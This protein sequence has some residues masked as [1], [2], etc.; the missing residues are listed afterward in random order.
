ME[1]Q[2]GRCVVINLPEEIQKLLGPVQ[3]GNPAHYFTGYDV[4]RDVQARRA[5]ALVIMGSPL[6][7]P[8]PK[9]QHWLSTIQRL[10]LSLLV[11]RQ[12]HGVVRRTQE[13]PNHIN[14]F[15][16]EVRIV[17]DLE[18]LQSVQLEI[19]HS[20]YLSDLLGGNASVLGHQP[21]APVRSFLGN[22]LCCQGQDFFDFLSAQLQ[23]LTATREVVQ[24]VD[25][26]L[27]ITLSP[28]EHGRC[29]DQ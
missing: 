29:R 16:G 3:L 5:M 7:L 15:L 4:E 9:L 25:A 19:G 14:D 18:C 28:L 21:D 12:H 11:N 17:A 27:Q 23:M 2:L 13:E 26:R 20:L 8:R 1:I 10:D 22:S 24:A 6:N